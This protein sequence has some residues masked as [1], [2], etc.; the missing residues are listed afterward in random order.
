MIIEIAASSGRPR[1]PSAHTPRAGDPVVPAL[2]AAGW[3][4]QIQGV[5]LYE[6]SSVFLREGK[7]LS[8]RR[9]SE[10]RRRILIEINRRVGVRLQD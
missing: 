10:Q 9:S 7:D 1:H 6:R 8:A 4:G 5:P 2:I 3:P